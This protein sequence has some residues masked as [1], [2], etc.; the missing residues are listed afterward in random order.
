MLELA[1]FR[2]IIF[3]KY[4]NG[5]TVVHKL[6]KFKRTNGGTCINQRPIVKKGE[7]VKKG[8]AI[9]DGPA[10]KDGE[11]SLGKNCLESPSLFT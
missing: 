8:D 1:S 9:A 10:T 4:N 7:I 3:V 2:V 11:M 5:K 6:R